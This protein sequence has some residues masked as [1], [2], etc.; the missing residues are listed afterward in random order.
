[1]AGTP[2]GTHAREGDLVQL[3]GLQHKNFIVRLREGGEFQSHRG[4]IRF[5]DLIGKE[6]GSQI[7]SHNGSPFFMLP[8]SLSDLLRGLKR[9]TQILYP[10]D[11]GYILV[12]MGIGP[13]KF[14][15]E[16]GTGSGSLT[17]A[18]AYAVGSSGCVSTYERRP[19]MQALAQKNLEALG[20]ESRVKWNLKDIA[21]GFDDRGADALF[22]DVANPWDYVNQVREALTP[23]GFFGSILPTFNQIAALIEA[24]R[25]NHFAFIDVVEILLRYYR[26]QPSRLRPTDRMVAHTGFLLFARPIQPVS[27][28]ASQRLLE[29]AGLAE[30]QD[31]GLE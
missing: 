29:E 26:T 12:T 1:M 4:V 8:P 23:G 19:E 17:A 5:D 11:V 18:F 20:L 22:L 7:F 16:A 24:L 10:K 13:G 14:V 31:E 25:A 27:D 2:E 21:E 28:G 9:N 3:V 30:D 15:V 6:W